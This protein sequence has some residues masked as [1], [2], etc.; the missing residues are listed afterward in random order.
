MAWLALS[1]P[2]YK[3]TWLHLKAVSASDSEVE[4]GAITELTK[5]EEAIW[6]S[7]NTN[8][9]YGTLGNFFF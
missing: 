2:T 6:A 3:C 8:I 7:S 9:A 4:A 1:N 5:P